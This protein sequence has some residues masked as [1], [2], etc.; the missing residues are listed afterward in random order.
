MLKAATVFIGHSFSPTMIDP[1]NHSFLAAAA[2]AGLP[3]FLLG[4]GFWDLRNRKRRVGFYRGSRQS[5]AHRGK[6]KSSL[7]IWLFSFYFPAKSFCRYH[8]KFSC[9]QHLPKHRRLVRVRGVHGCTPAPFHSIT[10][11]ARNRQT[12]GKD[13]VWFGETERKLA[14]LSQTTFTY[15][16]SS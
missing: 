5:W 8:S 12:D 10:I 6:F 16:S 1:G 7:K 2:T 4:R 11:T 13:L 15:R 9:W 3:P 14:K